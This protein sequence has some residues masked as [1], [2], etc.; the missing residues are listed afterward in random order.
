MSGYQ[1]LTGGLKIA[2]V[3][4]STALLSGQVNSLAA[5]AAVLAQKVGSALAARSVAYVEGSAPRELREAF[6]QSLTDLLDA[7]EQART[8]KK[9]QLHL[10]GTCHL[11]K[12]GDRGERLKVD[13]ELLDSADG[14]VLAHHRL[15]GAPTNYVQ[16]A[17]QFQK[18]FL[19]QIQQRWPQPGDAREPQPL[20][21]IQ[22][23][24][25][26]NA[27]RLRAAAGSP[28]FRLG[29][30]FTSAS[31]APADAPVYQDGDAVELR[32]SSER[33]CFAVIYN[34]DPAGELQRL[35]PA[36]PGRPGFLRAGQKLEL[37]EA[38]APPLRVFGNLGQE[39]VVALA[40][41]TELPGRKLLEANP[42]DIDD[43]VRALVDGALQGGSL[44]FSSAEPGGTVP[45]AGF[46]E[47][48]RADALRL[49]A[50]YSGSYALTPLDYY[51]EPRAR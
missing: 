40:W 4:P 14:K 49:G 35:W 17:D 13:L 28:P 12:E 2:S 29:L 51:T 30:E 38:G 48:V 43:L 32:C 50:T 24:R 46:P 36:R 42:G 19:R 21:R 1:P 16:M 3:S 39:S 34:V 15:E 45:L 7:Q 11:E 10:K 41:E 27:A 20:A 18:V 31:R 37:P 8:L 26:A 47:A 25:W 5:G 23:A 9:D 33:D 44:K 22:A 6:L